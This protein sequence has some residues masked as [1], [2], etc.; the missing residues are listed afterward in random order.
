[1]RHIINPLL[2]HR[3]MP[4]LV[5]LQVALACAIACNALFLLQQRVQ[6]ILAP[7]GIGQPERLLVATNVIARGT[8]WSAARLQGVAQA[9][10][11]LSGVGSAGVA[12]AL[13]MQTMA[14]MN[15]DVLADGGS[16][17]ANA[18]VYIGANLRA[19]LGLKLVAGRDFSAVEQG[20][21]YSDVGI[22]ANGPTLITRALADRLFPDGRALGKIV[23]IGRAADAARRTVVGVVEHLMR[24]QFGQ[25]NRDNLDYSLVFPGVPGSWP[26]PLYAVRV[27]DGAQVERVRKAVAELIH[28]E[29]GA[30]SVQGIEPRVERYAD[31]RQRMM[32]KSKAAVWLLAGVSLV[33]LIVTLVG[34]MG[35][36]SYWVQQR[37]RQI[38]IRRALGARCR[39]ILRDV[40]LEN[41]LVV[42]AGVVLGMALAYA[43]NLWLM[44]HYELLRLPWAYLPIGSM[45]MLVLGQLAVLGPARR[46]ARVPPVV[47]TRSL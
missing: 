19:T 43:I 24:N 32:A 7:D 15:G 26:V 25:D 46:A 17:S 1:M 8:P 45:L 30:E 37:T 33:V 22:N 4:L 14:Q 5:V 3:L 38:G 6:L 9:L 12:G 29:L 27:A 47:A 36:T 41:L 20:T 23:R 13:P 40:Q 35:L 42:A 16:D 18:A 39:D 34:V 11:A 2:R 31:L 44:H 28:R 21:Q 10:G